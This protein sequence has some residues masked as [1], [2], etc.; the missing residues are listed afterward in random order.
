MLK[1]A[2]R[3]IDHFYR[4]NE[5]FYRRNTVSGTIDAMSVECNRDNEPRIIDFDALVSADMALG[6]NT[7]LIQRSTV[8]ALFLNRNNMGQYIIRQNDGSAN[9]F[10]ARIEGDQI[11]EMHSPYNISYS[12]IEGR[13]ATIPVGST[14]IRAQSYGLLEDQVRL[15]HPEEF[16]QGESDSYNAALGDLFDKYRR[17]AIDHPVE[18]MKDTSRRRRRFGGFSIR[19]AKQ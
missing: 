13:T 6:P 7:G 10:H 14:L 8:E 16:E 12:S 4:P 19:S 2:T 15:L 17:F 1:T 3:G 9:V 11:L 5:F 18:S